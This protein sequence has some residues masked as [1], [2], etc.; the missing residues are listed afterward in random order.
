ML[1][2]LI[3]PAACRESRVSVFNLPLWVERVSGRWKTSAKGELLPMV[4]SRQWTVRDEVDSKSLPVVHG[5]IV[6]VAS[7]FSVRDRAQIALLIVWL[8]GASGDAVG[9]II[10]VNRRFWKRV[11]ADRQ[12]RL[13]SGG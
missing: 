12:E 4:V 9:W 7:T 1:V 11:A 6:V 2:K 5:E 3:L 8:V 10:W 13:T